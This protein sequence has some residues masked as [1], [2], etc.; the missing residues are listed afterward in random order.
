MEDMTVLKAMM[1][2]NVT[3]AGRVLLRWKALWRGYP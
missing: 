3:F 1:T 2:P